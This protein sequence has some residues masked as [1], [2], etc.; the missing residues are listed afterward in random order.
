M[1]LGYYDALR[2]KWITLDRNLSIDRRIDLI[3]EATVDDKPWWASV[4][5]WSKI[6]IHDLVAANII[7]DQVVVDMD[8]L[9]MT[10]EDAAKIV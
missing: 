1:E 2:A 6:N 4:G 3:N 10:I 5:M 7:T 9:G 8:Q